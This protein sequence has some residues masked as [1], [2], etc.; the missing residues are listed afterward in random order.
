MGQPGKGVVLVHEL[1]Q[2]GGREELLDGRHHRTDVDQGL[3]SDRLHV[4]GVH[5]LTHDALHAGETG[6][7]RVLD[8]LTDRTN[9]SV[10]EVV[11]V[12]DVVRRVLRRAVAGQVEQ[13]GRRRQHFGLREHVQALV[14]TLEQVAEEFDVLRHLVTQLAVQLVPSH[15]GEVVA[16]VGEESTLEVLTGG[17]D[18]LHFTRAGPSVDLEPRGLLRR[19]S[20]T[21][22]GVVVAELLHVLDDFGLGLLPVGEV[23]VLEEIEMLHELL[24]EALVHRGVKSA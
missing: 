4:L 2:L 23:L 10:G 22:G 13:V 16:L 1:T 19:P 11:L 7:Q 14:R 20:G 6:T 5:P 3:G 12:V 17:L 8:Q 9:A 21:L 15:R 24:E 18:G